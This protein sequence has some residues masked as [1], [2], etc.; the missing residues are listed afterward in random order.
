[1]K[2]FPLFQILTDLC[3]SFYYHCSYLLCV[4]QD[5]VLD[6][7]NQTRDLR[8]DLN[9]KDETI[10]HLS[11]DFKDLTVLSFFPILNFSTSVLCLKYLFVFVFQSKYSVACH[12][13]D[14]I[15]DQNQKLESQLSDIKEK[16]NRC[17]TSNKI[18]VEFHVGARLQSKRNVFISRAAV[19]TSSR[20][21]RCS[22]RRW[23]TPLK[24][25]R[26]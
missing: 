7:I 11:E 13:K 9:Q 24:R 23:L 22:R 12:E 10:T 1:M 26:D 14:K 3:W 21:W 15:A 4:W 16:M 5:V 19:L 17:I 20:R 25:L 2:F 8:S 6:L 18:E